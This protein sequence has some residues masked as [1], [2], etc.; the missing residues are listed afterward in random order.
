MFFKT[1]LN[2]DTTNGPAMPSK[3]FQYT[4][5]FEKKNF[6]DIV[7]PFVASPFEI[8]SKKLFNFFKPLR[9]P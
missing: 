9:L 8:F 1:F 5:F 2:G 4:M 6:F 3:I 7:G